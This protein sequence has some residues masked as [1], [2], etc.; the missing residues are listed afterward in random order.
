MV[1]GGSAAGSSVRST[2]AP[3]GGEDFRP[4][5]RPPL[6]LKLALGGLPQL[7]ADQRL[8]PVALDLLGR[9]VPASH[10]GEPHGQ[11]RHVDR[12]RADLHGVDP[13]G[14]PQPV[15]HAAGG[16][17][18]PVQRGLEGRAVEQ[19]EPFGAQLVFADLA[20]PPLPRRGC[21]QRVRDRDDV[22]EPLEHAGAHRHRVGQ[23]AR[24]DR[25]ADVDLLVGVE[26]GGVEAGDAAE[27]GQELVARKRAGE[28]EAETHPHLGPAEVGLGRVS[29]AARGLV[30]AR[31]VGEGVGQRSLSQAAVS[32]RRCRQSGSYSAPSMS[33]RTQWVGSSSNMG[34]MVAR[35]S[36]SSISASRF[37]LLTASGSTR[38]PSPALSMYA[39]CAPERR[40]TGSPS[41]GNQRPGAARMTQRSR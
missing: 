39:N 17:V 28:D 27:P 14:A 23:P 35:R 26:G 37:A 6:L 1:R 10:L 4:F 24:E 9:A 29:S 18:D 36:V 31:D 25:A 40:K 34:S 12:G 7:V 2:P 11:R 21:R 32:G 22:L 20:R 15:A 8:E 19:P 41:A 30:P 33:S 3:H 13:G 38:G 16:T 5:R